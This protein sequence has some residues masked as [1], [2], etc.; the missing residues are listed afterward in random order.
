MSE[1]VIV[2]NGSETKIAPAMGKFE[3]FLTPLGRAL[4]YRRHCPLAGPAKRVPRARRGDSRGSQSAG[5][6]AGLAD[7]RADAAEDRPC[8][9]R[10]GAKP[11][12]RD[13]CDGWNQLVGQAVLDG[14]ARLVIHWP[15][16]P[17]S[18]ACQSNRRYIAGLILLAAAP[19]TAMVFVWSNLVE[20]EPHFTLS[21]V[22]STAI[23]KAA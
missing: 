8:R 22:T 9:A 6:R 10:T 14:A 13:G 16:V 23:D 20:G 4:H 15:S 7:D 2:A 1:T 19:C 12:A 11:L 5:C 3:R 21:S 17:A 18:F